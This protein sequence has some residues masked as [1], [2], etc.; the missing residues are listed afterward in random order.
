MS[1]TSAHL[2]TCAIN[3]ELT[4]FQKGR[5]QHS[6]LSKPSKHY[7]AVSHSSI[8]P[9]TRA[10]GSVVMAKKGC[11]D[12]Q[13]HDTLT[14]RSRTIFHC[15]NYPLSPLQFYLFLYFSCFQNK[16]FLLQTKNKGRACVRVCKHKFL[17]LLFLNITRRIVVTNTQGSLIK[18]KAQTELSAQNQSRKRTE[19][20]C[21][22]S[23]ASRIT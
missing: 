3:T 5:G 2:K 4:R 15:W 22:Q 20:L 8:H 17:F 14:F 23:N 16:D 7:A 1:I 9:S 18:A 13:R 10:N 19:K 12:F 11:S 21:T 6:S